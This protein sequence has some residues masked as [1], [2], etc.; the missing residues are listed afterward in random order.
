MLVIRVYVVHGLF[1][2]SSTGS[3]ASSEHSVTSTGSSH[4]AISAK[5][6]LLANAD[7]SNNTAT[8]IQIKKAFGK[9]SDNM[10]ID[11]TLFNPDSLWMRPQSG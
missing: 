8:N 9:V 10:R 1:A 2:M 7:A 5:N 6:T 3:D 4:V 11:N